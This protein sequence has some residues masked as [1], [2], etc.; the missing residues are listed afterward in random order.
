M[1]A[2]IKFINRGTKTGEIWLYDT[3]GEGFFGGMSAKQFADELKGLGAVD[4][5][6]LRINSPGGNVFDGVAIYNQLQRH[7]AQIVVDVDGLAASIASVIAMAGDEIR[8]AENAM[9]MIHNPEGFSMGDAGE[10]R[11][12]ADLLDHIKGT[13][14]D[15]YGRRTKADVG[16]ISKWMADETW[17]SAGDAVANGFADSTTAEQPIAACYG[18]DLTQFRNAPPTMLARATGYPARDMRAV[19]LR[20]QEIRVRTLYSGDKQ[21]PAPLN[22]GFF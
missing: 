22:G 15:T 14:V 21:N 17:F 4:T 20:N 7:P 6:N 19:R 13:I 3:V 9:M 16:D 5:I 11:K 2:N 1:S 8:I 12:T 18:F 10:M